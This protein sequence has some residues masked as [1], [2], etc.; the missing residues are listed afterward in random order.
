LARF[1]LNLDVMANHTVPALT[2]GYRIGLTSSAALGLRY[3]F[4]TR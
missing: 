3:R 1:E 2:S 4:G